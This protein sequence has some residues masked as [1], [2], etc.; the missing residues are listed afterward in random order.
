[1]VNRNHWSMPGFTVL[2][3]LALTACS[4]G[5]SGGGGG[6]T[7]STPSGGVIG[8]G[9]GGETAG[10][11]GGETGSETAGETGGTGG[12]TDGGAGVGG[13]GGS[14]ETGGSSG[15][16][17]SGSGS[18]GGGTGSTGGGTPPVVDF[19]VP[20]PYATAGAANPAKLGRLFVFGDSYSDPFDPQRSCEPRRGTA[21]ATCL[22]P[23]DLWSSRLV[24]AA[25]GDPENLVSY[26]RGKASASNTNPYYVAALD[27]GLDGDKV[28]GDGVDK[29]FNERDNTFKAQVDQWKA[30]AHVLQGNDLTIVYMG[31][32][33]II[34][35]KSGWA[36]D[37]V[38]GYTTQLDELR[39]GGAASDGRRIFVTL[40]HD[41]GSVPNT[42]A[43]ST[44]RTNVLNNNLRE[45]VNGRDNVV[46][47]DMFTVFERIVADPA[48]YGF[49]NVTT[50]D[51]ENSDS[52]ALYFDGSHFGARGQEIL[53]QVY[54]H[55][56][57]RGW[58]WAN[59]LAAGSGAT[60]QLQ[61][62]I[63]DGLLLALDAQGPAQRQGFTTFFVG[64]R[65]AAALDAYELDTS[66][67]SRSGFMRLTQS[68]RPDTGL[69]L[70]YTL[71]DGSTLGVV[72]SRY[73]SDSGYANGVTT[74]RLD[75]QSDAVSLYLN[76]RVAGFD[77]RTTA[78]F[79]DDQ[80]NHSSFDTLVGERN[81]ASHGG[82]TMSLSQTASKAFRLDGAWLQPW[83]NIT[84]TQQQIDGYTISNPYVSDLTYSGA[85]V[86]DTVASLGL[87]ATGD[88][89]A[90][91]RRFGLTLTG[92]LSYTRSL[93]LDDYQV[94]VSEQA[95]GGLNQTET[96]EREGYETVGLR[97]GSVLDM[98]EA[99]SLSA[100]YALTK[101]VGV[102]TDHAITARFNYRF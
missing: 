74:S 9:A 36:T 47:V 33:D 29:N 83:V 76:T 79:A 102:E 8:G 38:T 81:A 42:K 45:I 24:A 60:Q 69:G 63:T 64:D 37:A 78:S 34:A 17:S 14:G 19:A 99:L 97:L 66:D 57:T 101:Q 77:L 71:N 53:A 85:E 12:E 3:L 84:H 1:M 75:S 49:E 30:D 82:R 80:Y 7:P 20:N 67:P 43:G 100:D 72:M 44:N 35:A 95:L 70:N 21:K 23:E 92:G 41:W 39:A 4:G 16:G 55:Y 6:G 93:H 25:G 28:A 58:D 73:G 68:Q 5:G 13:S 31:Y 22:A 51:A 52:T 62:D 18:T 46:A 59:T 26:A 40:V 65:D 91:D 61:D 88:R 89:I 86:N 87:N 54:N 50:A 27:N 98:G 94:Q 96:I 2:A 10:G 90:L 48:R 56:L 11:T 15:S 32:N